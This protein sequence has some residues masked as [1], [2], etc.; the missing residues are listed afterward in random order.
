MIIAFLKTAIPENLPNIYD[1]VGGAGIS[2]KYGR[3]LVF[4]VYSD[5]IILLSK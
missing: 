1:D 2:Y 3:N 4:I 5:Q